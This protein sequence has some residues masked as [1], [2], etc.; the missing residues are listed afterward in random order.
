MKSIRN[1]QGL[2]LVASITL[3]VFLGLLLGSAM[4]RTQL[5]LEEADTRLAAQQAFYAAETGVENAIYEIRRNPQW[6]PGENAPAVTDKVLRVDDSETATPV[7]LYSIEVV[8]ADNFKGFESVWVK[9]TGKDTT[10][11]IARSIRARLI[12]EDPTAFFVSTAG[13]LRIGSGSS[14]DNNI[15]GKDIFFDVDES[16]LAPEKKQITINGD[17]FFLGQV[18]GIPHPSVHINGGIAKSPT[19]TFAGV[20]L[21]RY[22]GIAQHGGGRYESGDFIY[23]GDID[24]ANLATA[25]GLVFAEGDVHISGVIKDSLLIVA[26]GNIYVEDDLVPALPPGGGSEETAPQLGLL[27]KKD[28]IIPEGAPDEISIEAFIMADGDTG[29]QGGIFTAAGQKFNKSTINFHGA[30]A[31]RGQDA[32]TAA[33]LNVYQTRNYSYNTQLR[34]NRKIPFL[35]FVAIIVRWEE[36]NPGDPLPNSGG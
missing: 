2:A 23:N 13:D 16:I 33:D 1:N 7:G 36:T 15:L 17:I 29:S 10:G 4:L 35:P 3:T 31:V 19:V 30:I 11:K 8:D 9:S 21:E 25:N 26:G 18:F 5:Q 34:E 12:V 32:R 6:R 14:F 24:L 20:D 27:A 22:R 28:V